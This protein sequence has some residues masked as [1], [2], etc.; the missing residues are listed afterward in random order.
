MTN[1]NEVILDK[2]KNTF[3]NLLLNE[4]KEDIKD[5]AGC[6][7]D[8]KLYNL[9]DEIPEK[10]EFEIVKFN[11]DAGMKI[12]INTLQFIFIKCVLDMLPKARITLQHS[13]SQSIYGEIHNECDINEEDLK[14]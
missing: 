1:N 8:G 9:N 3:Y 4:H 12:Y 10:G 5:I 6:K 13:F 14:R 2:K 7:L 11:T